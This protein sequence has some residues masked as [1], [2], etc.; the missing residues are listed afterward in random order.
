MRHLI[1]CIFAIIGCSDRAPSES[2]TFYV[3]RMVSGFHV[4]RL[5]PTGG[6][7]DDVH[8]FSSTRSVFVSTV[9][10]KYRP[11]EVYFTYEDGMEMVSYI[12]EGERLK[13]Y[14]PNEPCKA[15]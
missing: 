3:M 7:Y 11:G 15:E 10:P 6:W 13:L 9:T 14:A 2:E 12:Y 1:L 8:C 5:S 4:T